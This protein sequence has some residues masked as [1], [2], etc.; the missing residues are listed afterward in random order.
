[1]TVMCSQAHLRRILAETDSSNPTNMV[2]LPNGGILLMSLKPY[3]D[4][5][6][7]YFISRDEDHK[8]DSLV[9]EQEDVIG[10]LIG[11]LVFELAHSFAHI[12]YKVVQ[13]RKNNKKIG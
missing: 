13:T 7:G 3:E 1:M 6:G 8:G 5:N 2:M 4:T 9:D 11:I 10:Q 12:V